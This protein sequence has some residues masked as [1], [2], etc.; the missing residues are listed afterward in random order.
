MRTGV[1]V[2][3]LFFSFHKSNFRVE[4]FLHLLNTSL[5]CL[6]F[7]AICSV[8]RI[9]FESFLCQIRRAHLQKLLSDE[10]AKHEKELNAMGKSFYKKRI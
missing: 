6:S 9:W 2:A 3:R 1:R 5:I 8:M 4:A 7:V 10:N